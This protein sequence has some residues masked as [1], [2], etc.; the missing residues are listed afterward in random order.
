M[1]QIL[2][3]K[4]QQV[5]VVFVKNRL[6]VTVREA[7]KM[8]ALRNSRLIAGRRGLNRVI[9]W[10]NVMEVPDILDWVKEGEFLIT[11]GFS[12][13]DD[14]AAQERLI[15]ELARRGLAGLGIKL[16]RYIHRVPQSMIEAADSLDFPL[17]ELPLEASFPDIMNPIMSEVVNRQAAFL[18]QAEEIHRYLMEVVLAGKG[19]GG[20]AETLADLIHSPVYIESRLWDKAV[21]AAARSDLTLEELLSG[22]AGN[23]AGEGV[24]ESGSEPGSRFVSDQVDFRGKRIRKISVPIVAAGSRH[25]RITVWEISHRLS[26][27]D[28]R[29]IERATTIAALEIINERA[30]YEVER[31]YR[32]EFLD[33]LLSGSFDSE[34]AALE[35][36]RALGWDLTRNLVAL[37]IETDQPVPRGDGDQHYTEVKNQILRSAGVAL[38]GNCVVGE[39]GK[40]VVVLVPAGV[41]L[42][43]IRGEALRAA[44]QIEAVLSKSLRGISFWIG[45]G[46]FHPTLKGLSTS[47]QE[48]LKALGIGRTLSGGTRVI[49]FDDLG[50]YR[51]LHLVRGEQELFSFFEETIGP[52]VRYDNEKNTSLVKTLE[53]YFECGGNLRKMAEKLFTHYNTVTYRI[54]RIQQILGVNLDNAPDRLNL[55]I[56]LKIMKFSNYGIEPKQTDGVCE[57]FIKGMAP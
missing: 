37:V 43:A 29:A 4:T 51:L 53:A 48:A 12:I 5:G 49:H 13:K 46:R 35:R 11:T 38:G 15:P 2:M 32:N 26:D 21:F 39:K 40:G 30:V 28:L 54:E 10:V 23:A 33:D 41:D 27:L 56:G 34:Q 16:K 57:T 3:E 36:S 19:L 7:L 52:L 45:L 18:K 8:E 44:R 31:R 55:E 22:Q 1:C 17:I 6:G 14:P 20:L 50:V 25:G 9:H 24:E 42:S 47:Y